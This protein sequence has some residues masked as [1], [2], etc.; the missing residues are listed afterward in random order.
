MVGLRWTGVS[1]T[2]NQDLSIKPLNCGH[3]PRGGGERPGL[4]AAGGHCG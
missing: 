4:G 2:I 1:L 3:D